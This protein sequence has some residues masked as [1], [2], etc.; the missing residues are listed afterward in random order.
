MTSKFA[1]NLL[2]SMS[3]AA[4]A[5]GL[6][7]GANALTVRDDVTVEG[8]EDRADDPQYD[9]VVQI[10]FALPDGRIIFNCTGS[11][12]NARTV[13]SAAHCFND[14]PSTAFGLQ[15]GQI[16]P[17]VAYGPDTFDGLF[18]WLGTGN[19]ELDDR[20]GITFGNQVIIHPDADPA[21]G[22]ALDFPAADVAMISLNNPL[23]NLPTYSMLFSP[24]PVGTHVQMVAYGG[25]G[26]GTT[27][28][29]SIDGK[30]QA[31]ENILGL[32]GSQNDFLRGAFGS[33]NTYFGAPDGDQLLYYTD[34]DN[35]VRDTSVCSRD[36]DFFGFFGLVCDDPAKPINGTFGIGDEVVVV[37]DDIDW[38][39]GGDALPNES[40]TAGGD[41]GSA[42]FADELIPGELLIT[43]VLS[44]GF[45]FT[46]PAPSGYGDVSYYNPLFLFHDFISEANPYKY[47]SAVEGDGNWSDAGHWQQQLDPG[48]L[49]IDAEGNV[50]NGLPDGP[51]LGVVG[52]DPREGIVFDTDIN[53][54]VPGAQPADPEAG[55][56]TG[57]RQLGSIGGLERVN[58]AAS[59]TVAVTG[60]AGQITTLATA[61]APTDLTADGVLATRNLANGPIVDEELVTFLYGDVGSPGSFNGPGA[62]GVPN[63]GL[64]AEGF[65]NYFEITLNAAGTTTADIDATVDKLTLDNA[66]A[67]LAVADGVA[68]ISLVDTQIIQGELDVSGIFASRDILNFDRVTGA[69]GGEIITDTL[70]NAG[71]LSAG[72][73]LDVFGDVVF[74][75]AGTLLYQGSSLDV[76]GDVSID[77][78]LMLASNAPGQSGTLLTHTGDRIGE[79]GLGQFNN[80]VGARRIN[81]DYGTSAVDFT[82]TQEALTSFLSETSLT[83]NDLAMAALLDSLRGDAGGISNVFETVDFLSASELESRFGGLTP[84]NAFQG[85]GLGQLAG[86]SLPTHIGRRLNGLSSGLAAGVHFNS[87]AGHV[88]LASLNDQSIY[89]LV[90]QAE[91]ASEGGS[92][93]ANAIGT[94]DTGQEIGAFME[95]S[96]STGSHDAGIGN[97]A[98]DIDG[99]AITIG[100]DTAFTPTLRGGVFGHYS[101]GESD[102]SSGLGA[103]ESDGFTIGAY[104]TAAY[105]GTNIAGYAGFGQRNFDTIRNGLFSALEGSTDADEIVAGVSISRDYVVDAST[106]YTAVPELRVDYQTYDIASYTEQG[107][108]TALEIDGRDFSSLLVKVGGDMHFYDVTSTE[109]AGFK[110]SLGA[111]IVYDLDGSRDTTTARFAMAPGGQAV[112]AGADRDKSWGELRGA[113]NFASAN[114]PVSAS[115]FAE[116]TVGRDDISY[117]TLGLNVKGRF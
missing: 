97:V 55:S 61:A 96:V 27:G 71:L 99:T 41:S 28:D 104:G 105:S 117:V 111:R 86:S 45:S 73:G 106:G 72:T 108:M 49:I 33:T 56:P 67:T 35:P 70:F 7:P 91:T 95:V 90:D 3:F 30:R 63:N 113:L 98:S 18:N 47:V 112:L 24:V 51:E 84:T 46:A 52:T 75:S 54:L 39:P 25:H 12:I 9:G 79:F 101:E 5:A 31:G 22:P 32:V 38:F 94:V 57:D 109:F 13:I 4:L 66:D 48:Y 40:G 116:G 23:S 85:P 60:D 19:L 42:L 44:G 93:S 87:N 16:T 15:T 10:Y 83:D 92:G 78:Q 114:A 59:G 2:A 76:A 107:D 36:N 26:T 62:S 110:P 34:F 68:L 65:F 6:A 81:L 8:S 17:I 88:Q 50:V 14:S 100:L 80:N 115:L 11:L 29:V 37:T 1:K 21:F 58:F 102:F 20:N 82:V 74:T 53:D 89:N 64:N 103:A 77:G 43:G 69:D